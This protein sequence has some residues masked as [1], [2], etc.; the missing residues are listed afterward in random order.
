M[1]DTNC[2]V[3]LAKGKLPENVK[4]R[5]SS[6]LDDQPRISII[7]KIPNAIIAA[8]A[9]RNNLT[10]ITHN[11]ADFKMVKGLALINRGINSFFVVT[12]A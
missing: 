3:E 2:I 10:R 8:T 12:L 4:N 1:I 7:N 11:S 6:A 5:L 9:K